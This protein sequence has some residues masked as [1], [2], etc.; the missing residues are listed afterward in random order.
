[1]KEFIDNLTER[2]YQKRTIGI[3]ENGSWAPMAEKTIK[4]MFEKSKEIT[5]LDNSVRILS[6]PDEKNLDEIKKLA[7]EI[8]K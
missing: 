4:A 7:E 2:N 1:M 3:I 5:F 6:S 8:M